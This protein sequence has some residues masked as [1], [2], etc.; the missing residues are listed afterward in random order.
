MPLRRKKG[1]YVLTRYD[2]KVSGPFRTRKEAVASLK[3]N[4]GIRYKTIQRY[5]ASHDGLV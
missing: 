3:A 2:T 1:H 4:P 5:Y